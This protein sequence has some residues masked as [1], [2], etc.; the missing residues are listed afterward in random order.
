MLGLMGIRLLAD[1]VTTLTS[2]AFAGH[3]IITCK[4]SY[5]CD[6][7]TGN[8]LHIEWLFNLWLQLSTSSGTSIFNCQMEM[9]LPQWSEDRNRK[10][11]LL[12]EN[13]LFVV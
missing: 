10:T 13:L 7:R 6:F 3:I 1:D 2:A 12:K 9:E 5:S 11:R 8:C 4:L